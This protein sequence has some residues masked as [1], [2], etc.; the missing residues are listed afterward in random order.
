VNDQSE[1]QSVQR[2]KLPAIVLFLCFLLQIVFGAFVAG[3][4]AGLYYPTWP[5]MGDQWF[6]SDTILISD[7]I[8]TNFFENG[9]GVQFV[10]RTFAAIVVIALLWLWRISSVLKLNRY[11][12]SAITLLIYGLTI[13]VMLG[14]YTLLY[15][16]PIILGVLHQTGAFF[17][18]T[19]SI[20]L[21][22]HLF[23]KPYGR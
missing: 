23:R 13:Q 11:V 3:L 12:Q 4:K 15:Q 17:L 10:H 6:P 8:R 16:V 1:A 5:K 21:L 22:F 19:V 9:A 20:Y 14:V 18:F 7:S 2:L